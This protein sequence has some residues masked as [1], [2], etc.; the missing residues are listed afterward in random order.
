MLV[1]DIDTIVL[2]GFASITQSDC[3]AWITSSGFDH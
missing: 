3:Q 2:A 1:V